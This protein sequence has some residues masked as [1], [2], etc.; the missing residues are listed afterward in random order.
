MSRVSEKSESLKSEKRKKKKRK[1]KKQKSLE[2]R[3]GIVF[4]VKGRIGK[5]LF[6]NFYIYIHAEPV[7]RL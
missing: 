1:K 6:F 3:G 7:A 2:K 5:F 4:R